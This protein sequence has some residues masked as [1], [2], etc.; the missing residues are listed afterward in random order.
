MAVAVAEFH[1]C[2]PC[3]KFVLP[4]RYIFKDFHALKLM[5]DLLEICNQVHV[6]D[7]FC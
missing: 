1:D 5:S 2:R 6:A 3:H 7:I 4:F